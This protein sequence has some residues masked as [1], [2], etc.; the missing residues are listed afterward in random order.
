MKKIL[1]VLSFCCLF[2]FGCS[3]S[4]SILNEAT[5]SDEDLTYIKNEFSNF[6]VNYDKKE[7]SIL[8]TPNE[9]TKNLLRFLL[10]N[11]DAGAITF[12]PN[13]PGNQNFFGYAIIYDPTPKALQKSKELAIKGLNDP[14]A[15]RN[16]ISFLLKLYKSDFNQKYDVIYRF[17]LSYNLDEDHSQTLL[18]YLSDGKS[19]YVVPFDKLVDDLLSIS[20]RFTDKYKKGLT[21]IIQIEDE[22]VAE[23]S[24]NYIVYNEM[25]NVRDLYNFDI[26]EIISFADYK[27]RRLTDNDFELDNIDTDN[28]V[29]PTPSANSLADAL[30]NG[31]SLIEV[32]SRNGVN[33]YKNSKSDNS[34]DAFNEEVATGD[35]Y[36]IFDRVDEIMNVEPKGDSTSDLIDFFGM[37]LQSLDNAFSEFLTLV[38]ENDSVKDEYLNEFK[39]AREQYAND[40]QIE[41]TGSAGTLNYLIDE[42]YFTLNDLSRNVEIQTG[43]PLDLD[44]YEVEKLDT[45]KY[46]KTNIPQFDFT[47]DEGQ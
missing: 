42:I 21:I 46:I 1:I 34:Y 44:K 26:K 20:Q 35:P 12:D 19:P 37:Q 30:E 45:S 2:L 33:E 40:N 9:D 7:N 17:C 8:L 5:L 6:N 22:K 39:N 41:D 32:F 16:F 10:N 36:Y 14:E 24:G 18:N 4:N 11:G 13:A 3:N 15:R 38:A 29:Q 28:F 25:D 31:G 27:N 43:G 23:V 47:N